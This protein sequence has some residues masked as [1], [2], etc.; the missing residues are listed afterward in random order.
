[1]SDNRIEGAG[2]KLKGSIKEGL[3]KLTGDRQMQ[4]EGVAEKLG[5]SVQNTVGKVQDHIAG[6]PRPF[7]DH[8]RVDGTGKKIAGSIKEGVG[9]LTGNRKMQ[10]EG[11]AEKAAGSVQDGFGKAKDTLR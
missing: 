5:G 7:A 2:H 3:G 10:A 11:A 9:K 8:D 6:E 1:M 4:A